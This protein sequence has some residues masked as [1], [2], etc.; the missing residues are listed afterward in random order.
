MKF[1][2]KRALVHISP[3]R[4]LMMSFDGFESIICTEKWIVRWQ[5]RML[6][7]KWNRFVPCERIRRTRLEWRN[8]RSRHLFTRVPKFDNKKAATKLIP[9]IPF[10]SSFHLRLPCNE[11]RWLPFV[12]LPETLYKLDSL[13]IKH[14]PAASLFVWLVE[15]RWEWKAIKITRKLPVLVAAYSIPLS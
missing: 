3:S 14:S 5:T 7:R 2:C 8:G 9:G 1:S 10:A 12:R 11:F 6:T 13:S 15:S 4:A